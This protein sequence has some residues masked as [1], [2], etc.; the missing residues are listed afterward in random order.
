MT[1][2][3][4][5]L[6]TLRDFIRWGV[7]RFNEAGL[8]FGHGTNNALDEA[9]LL[10]FHALH[11][12]H[13]LPVAY[14]ESRL[15]PAERGCVSALL[16]RRID[17]RLPAAYLTHEAWFAGFLFYVNEHV[18]V[19]RSPIA[20]LIEQGFSPW[21]EEQRVRGILDLCTG[22][23]CIAIS[24]AYRFPDA[25][26]DAVD[27]SSEALGVASINIGRHGMEGRVEA[28][29][30]DLFT[31]L[32][33]RRYDIIVSNPPYVSWQEMEQLPAEYHREPSLSLEAGEDGLD[34]VVRILREA[35]NYLEPDGIMVVE[36]GSSAEALMARYPEVAFLW[37]DF[38]RG[39]D[40]VFLLTAG[41]LEQFF[42]VE[43]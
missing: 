8:F 4:A 29:C 28:V 25:R 36:V 41:Q 39:G 18:L 17:E 42:S 23:G 2:N 43:G 5:S 11:L 3:R 12:P 27:I 31:A 40:G 38:E 20:E 14:L 1:E 26:I 15:T 35:T 24:C 37:L 16:D 32:E 19:P 34:V 10:V 13:D 33:G 21:V 22:S 9:V 30:S 6:K 7:S